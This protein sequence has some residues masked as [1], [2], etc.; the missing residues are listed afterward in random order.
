MSKEQC[1]RQ[2]SKRLCEDACKESQIP[3]WA[4]DARLLERCIEDPS[5]SEQEDGLQSV[6]VPKS[7]TRKRDREK[8]T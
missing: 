5:Y 1:P 6:D 2:S 4:F 7:G 8:P 3:K